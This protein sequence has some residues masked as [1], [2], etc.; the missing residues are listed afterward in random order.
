MLALGTPCPEFQLVDP[1]GRV[2][3]LADFDDARGLLV[4]FMC[5]H[6]PF[7]IHLREAL[8]RFGREAQGLGIAVIAINSNDAV[9][10]P[11]DAP[12]KMVA[13]ARLAGYTFP[14]VTD[15]D[16]SAAYAFRAACTPD[17]YLFDT[18]HLLVYRGQFDESRPDSGHEI[19][20]ADLR[21]AVHA[22]LGG[23]DPVS[24]QMPSMGCNIKWKPGN[25]PEWFAT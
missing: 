9:K 24:D 14:Y 22:L 25:E 19:T 21:A 7:V 23:D 20:G 13:E 8:S 12:D 10:Y 2:Y 17:F 3:R 5:N 4:I 18:E 15:P 1:D 11:A 6:C 16:Q